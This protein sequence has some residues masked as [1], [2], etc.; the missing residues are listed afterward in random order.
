MRKP[1]CLKRPALFS[2]ISFVALLFVTVAA[3]TL[4]F[5]AGSAQAAQ[6]AFSWS[7]PTTFVDG[8]SL[9]TLRGYKVYTGTASGS[10]AQSVDVGN[11][12]SYTNSGL[13]DGTTY[14]F[15]VTAYD[16]AGDV[17]GYSN[18]V[19]Y[20]TPAAPPP[21]T[22]YTLTASA[23]SGGSITPSGATVVSSGAGQSY[24]IT[25]NSGYKIAG[26][27]VDGASV[28]AVSSY[29]F[30]KVTANHTIAATF[31]AN[32]TSY[33]ITASAGTGGSITPAGSTTV[34]AGASQSYTVTPSTGYYLA[35]LLVDG[36]AVASNV[37][38]GA[39]YSYAFSSVSATHTISASFAVRSYHLVATAGTGGSVTPADSWVVY[40]ASQTTTITP[41][42]GYQVT[43]VQVD[44][45]SVGAVTSYT[46]ANLAA[47][48]TLSATFAAGYTISASAGSNGT[49]T[50]AGTT[51]V[52]A[53]ASKSY[54]VT[55]STGYYL[56][57]LLVDG[58]AVASN[59]PG[60]APYSYTFSNAA[61]NH[62]ISA[63]FGV[64]Y[65]N[66]AA[67]AGSNGSVSPG[68][69]WVLYNTPQTIAITPSSGHTVAGVT[70]DG[71]SVGAVSSYTFSNVAADHTLI[72]TFK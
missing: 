72:A 17:S 41:S 52:L 43:D 36:T 11:V 8:S 68:G 54:T 5:G 20:S 63:T 58:T 55:P 64:R 9:T 50:P 69:I 12:N 40:N 47:D 30:S 42:S 24:T 59:V 4:Q 19:T 22:L 60:S 51:S 21:A 26:V 44:G 25:A 57:S 1:S 31:A 2:R 46:F 6:A 70:V 15:A 61:A 67:S 71:V 3:V 49:I 56:A 62:T 38:G 35:S 13:A 34:S 66:I 48:H 29:A 32:V 14:Y 39:P 10:Y 18:Q 33:A 65:Y 27:T 45:K 37:A 28:G 7:T 53:G 23:G 16:A